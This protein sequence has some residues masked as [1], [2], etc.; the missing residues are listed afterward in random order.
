MVLRD[1]KGRARC[2]CCGASCETTSRIWALGVPAQVSD[3]CRISKRDEGAGAEEAVAVVPGCGF[4]EEIHPSTIH[5]SDCD[6]PMCS[7][8]ARGLARCAAT[9]DHHL[10]PINELSPL[11]AQTSTVCP[12]YDRLLEMFDRTCD[13][14]VCLAC[15]VGAHKNHE[16]VDI[17]LVVDEKRA[18][19][20]SATERCRAH[21][22]A[23]TESEAQTRGI[24]ARLPVKNWRKVLR[25]WWSVRRYFDNFR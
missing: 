7:I 15:C 12:V 2:L 9:K 24:S 8:M 19:L 18:L 23:I 13:K 22:D 10:I 1:V 21:V 25:S 6:Q 20:I 16:L 11:R 3:L 14:P 5:C 17:G 4:C